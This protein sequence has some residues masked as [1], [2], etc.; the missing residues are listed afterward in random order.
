[1]QGMWGCCLG[2][3]M[4]QSSVDICSDLVSA[5]GYITPTGVSKCTQLKFY[6][7]EVTTVPARLIRD[8]SAFAVQR[9]AA[10]VGFQGLSPASRDSILANSNV[11]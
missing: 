7:N 11:C 4:E 2:M 8:M 1:M 6:D 3:P 10:R 5:G 9:V